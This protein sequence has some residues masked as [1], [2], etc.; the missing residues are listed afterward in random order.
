MGQYLIAAAVMSIA[1]LLW[2]NLTNFGSL[3]TTLGGVLIG[4]GLYFAVSAVLK[5]EELGLL[6][7][8]LKR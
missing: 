1:L 4:V 7:G 3:I 2:K 8:M 5:V 6:K